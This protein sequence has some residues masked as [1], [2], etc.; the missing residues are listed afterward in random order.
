MTKLVL[1]R[2]LCQFPVSSDTLERQLH[3]HTIGYSAHNKNL[4]A[5]LGIFLSIHYIVNEVGREFRRKGRPCARINLACHCA[6]IIVRVRSGKNNRIV[7]AL[8]LESRV[9]DKTLIKCEE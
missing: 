4:L 5:S 1:F 3:F 7:Q 6:E 2:Q 8:N 9:G